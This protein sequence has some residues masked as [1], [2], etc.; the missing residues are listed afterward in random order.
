[1]VPLDRGKRTKTLVGGTRKYRKE[2]KGRGWQKYSRTVKEMK[3]IDRYTSK[4]EVA[5]VKE[6]TLSELYVRLDTRKEKRTYISLPRKLTAW[7]IK[8]RWLRIKM[9]IY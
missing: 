8:L 7:E 9:E 1:M 4:R 2:F 6:K 3:T 5:A